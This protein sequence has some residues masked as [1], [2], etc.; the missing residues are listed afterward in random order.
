MSIPLRVTFLGT[1][2]VHPT[3]RRGTTATY[4]VRGGD[5]W[6][7]D[8]GEGT[9][10]K[11]WAATGG[12]P[13]LD[14]I[15]LTHY[16]ADHTLGLIGLVSTMDLWGR[17]RPLS[18]YGPP[19][20]NGMRDA[21]AP[22]VTLMPKSARK[23]IRWCEVGTDACAAR[24]AD[25]QFATFPVIHARGRS[26]GYALLEDTK[27]GKIDAVLCEGAG[28]TGPEIGRVKK[29]ETVKGVRP[30]DVIG[31]DIVGRKVV[32]TGDTAPSAQVAKAADRAD[33]LVH[34]ATYLRGQ[35]RDSDHS[36]AFAAGE[37]AS[38]AGVKRLALTHIAARNT[39]KAIEAEARMTYAGDLLVPRDLQHIDL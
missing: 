29:G 17:T 26:Q 22:H 13:D 21:L 2:A 15:F 14:G 8:C 33:L 38:K 39:N 36:T 34:E 10:A 5:K 6:L 32:V 23:L 12:L 28:L 16:H 1:G 4:I 27:V 37:I 20:L 3:A 19:G 30:Q 7:I 18:I 24:M 25:Y 31:P 11:L 9:Q 35:E